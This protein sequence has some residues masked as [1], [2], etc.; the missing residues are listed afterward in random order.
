MTEHQPARHKKTKRGPRRSRR[1]EWCGK[2]PDGPDPCICTWRDKLTAARSRL[3]AQSSS[4][5][6][7]PAALS[8]FQAGRGWPFGSSAL[9]LL[10]LGSYPLLQIAHG[11]YGALGTLRPELAHGL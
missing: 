4:E 11:G 10:T 3:V 2:L 1:C 7:R 6:P 8:R 5:T 9:S